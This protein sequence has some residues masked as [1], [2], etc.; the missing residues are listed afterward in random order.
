M[1]FLN[2]PDVL[3]E[4]MRFIV[5]VLLAR[6]GAL[7]EDELL[8]LISPLGLSE[9]IAGEKKDIEEESE[10]ATR[11]RTGGR[12]IVK[13]S[14]T[15][16]R[17]AGLV[18]PGPQGD[19][20]IRVTKDVQGA[21]VDVTCLGIDLTER[22]YMEEKLSKSASQ[23][24]HHLGLVSS[25]INSIPDIVFYKNLDGIYLGCNAEFARHLGK[26]IDDILGKTDYDLYDRSEANAFRENEHR[27]DAAP[28]LA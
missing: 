16:M 10:P 23:I 20:G 21:I 24:R 3:P 13:A 25:L 5:R 17:A 12:T 2:P 19:K 6:G 27:D 28:S 18:E 14:L 9:A 15:A 8:T 4:A 26:E 1:P 11:F 7:S 22:K